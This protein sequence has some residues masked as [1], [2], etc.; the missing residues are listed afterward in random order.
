[1]H[2]LYPL[3]GQPDQYVLLFRNVAPKTT[4]NDLYDN[5]Q[6]Q[7]LVK[8]LGDHTSLTDPILKTQGTMGFEVLNDALGHIAGLLAVT[9]FEREPWLFA[10]TCEDRKVVRKRCI[11]CFL[12]RPDDLVKFTDWNWCR[13]AVRVERPWHWFRVVALHCIAKTWQEERARTEQREKSTDIGRD[14]PLV[15]EQERHER[16]RTVSLGLYADERPVGSPYEID[17]DTQLASLRKYGVTF[18]DQPRSSTGAD[19]E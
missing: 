15:D 1:M 5:P 9:P 18:A 13:T 6:A 12:L 11:R 14:M 17:W 2:R 10:M 7:S 19:H 8:D 16:V 3:A 4:L